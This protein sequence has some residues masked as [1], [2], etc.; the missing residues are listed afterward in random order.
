LVDY[1]ISQDATIQLVFS[2]EGGAKKRKKKQYTTPKKIKHKHKK[3]YL[4][5]LLYWRA[6]IAGRKWLR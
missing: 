1:S 6:D 4:P 3:Y 5:Q 2:L